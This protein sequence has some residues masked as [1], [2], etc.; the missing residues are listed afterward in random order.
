VLAFASHA[1]MQVGGVYIAAAGHRGVKQCAG[2]VFTDHGT[3]GAGGNTLG[4][5]H[6]DGRETM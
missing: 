1:L 6:D 2:G 3:G 4:R 5:R